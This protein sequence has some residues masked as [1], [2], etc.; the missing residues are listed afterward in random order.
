MFAA[1]VSI[2]VGLLVVFS[3]PWDPMP[4]EARV[5]EVEQSVAAAPQSAPVP[6]PEAEPE[7]LVFTVA[8][9]G[10]ILIHM[11]V[12]ASAQTEGGW[13]FSTVFEPIRPQLESADIALCNLETPITPPGVPISG[14]PMFGA[15]EPL[16]G[17]L[18]AAGFD[19][20]STANNHSVDRGFAGISHTLDL[21]DEQ[22]L[23][24][25][26]TA[27]TAEEAAKPQLY[28]VEGEG[29]SVTVAHLSAADNLNGLPMP[30]EAPWAVDM[31]DAERINEQ[32]MAAREAGADVVIVSLH[33]CV[34]E[35]VTTP[36]DQMISVNEYLAEQGNVDAVF[37]THAHVPQPVEMLEGGP[38]GEGMWVAYG[39]GNF[40]SN[41]SV[42]CCGPNTESGLLVAFTFVKEDGEAPH[43][44]E[45][46]WQVVTVDQASGHQVFPLT[47]GI[48]EGSLISEEEAQRRYAGVTQIL[49]GTLASEAQGLYESTA[50]KVTVVPRS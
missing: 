18:A 45:A 17:G 36:E 42:S 44:A 32:A 40:V 26:G 5:V 15:P 27:R 7:P 48:A 21:F 22:G 19:G 24:H 41:Q 38:G 14:F 3:R 4:I 46:S 47:A 20:C 37:G 39:L 43:V 25:V 10:D 35:Y 9:G 49:E 34:V 23:G 50:E 12:A 30:E 28:V 2:A 29:Q 33:C 6:E 1:V 31:I 8:G 13:D 11:P 16:A